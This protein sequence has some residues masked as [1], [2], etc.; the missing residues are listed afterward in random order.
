MK[1]FHVQLLF[2]QKAELLGKNLT[3]FAVQPFRFIKII[4]PTE[5]I[6]KRDQFSL[7]DQREEKRESLI[8]NSLGFFTKIFSAIVFV[9]RT[10]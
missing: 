10:G 1:I 8:S 7:I 9:N 6:K 5:I 4:S 2:E 3:D